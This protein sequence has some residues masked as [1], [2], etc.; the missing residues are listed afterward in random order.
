MQ[1][2]KFIAPNGARVNI[3]N[4]SEFLK[5]FSSDIAMHVIFADPML[6]A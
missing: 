4:W 6:N 1:N 2:I 5:T 3:K